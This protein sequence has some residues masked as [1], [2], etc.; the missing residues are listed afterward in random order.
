MQN[1]PK[2]SVIIPLFNRS[3]LIP[4]TL[5]SVR[6]QSYPH[7]EVIV[8][9]D[10][11]TDNSIE[12]VQ[13]FAR[14]DKR[15]RV[16]SRQR[17]PKGAPTCRNIGVER[18][19]G[20]Y[21]IFL[22]SDDLLAPYCLQR[23]LAFMQAHPQLD[24]AVFLMMDFKKQLGD[25]RT[26][27]NVFNDENDLERFLGKGMTWQTTGPIWRKSALVKVGNWE[28][29]AVSWQD[30]EFHVR[31]LAKGLTYEKVDGLPDCFVRRDDSDRISKEGW[32]KRKILSRTKL[33]SKVYLLLVETQQPEYI[34]KRIVGYFYT[35]VEA[36]AL[37]QPELNAQALFEPVRSFKLVTPLQVAMA[38]QSIRLRQWAHRRSPI[39]SR[40]V[41]RL[42]T[43]LL[44]NVFFHE[45][46]RQHTHQLDAGLHKK[47]ISDL[48]K[49][50]ETKKRDA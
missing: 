1:H 25:C 4:E 6:S 36:A 13:Q 47:M 24:F 23:R 15:I 31:A 7:W 10:G 33:F 38:W 40:L 35:Y 28:E 26:L 11:S 32:T 9:D 14:H 44:P 17:E 37:H 5:D 18:A 12:V 19:C 46:S 45:P 39:L 34:V 21:V 27:W 50:F 3:S 43:R 2:I 29:E 22:D 49:T 16:F 41:R 42:N 48:H 30:W 20:E 8:V